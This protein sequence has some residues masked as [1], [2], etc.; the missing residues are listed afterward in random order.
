VEFR[1]FGGV[2]KVADFVNVVVYRLK[3]CC[4]LYFRSGTTLAFMAWLDAL[5]I[6]QVNRRGAD[7]FVSEY[8]NNRSNQCHCAVGCEVVNF[9]PSISTS[10]LTTLNGADE[11]PEIRLRY[12]RAMEVTSRVNEDALNDV[13]W[14]LQNVSYV[15]MF[16][17]ALTSIDYI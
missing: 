6:P 4:F 13:T 15:M 7:A 10:Q 11:D 5:I 17:F 12:Q 9:L 14:K 3:N 16:F 1:E 8:S 2:I